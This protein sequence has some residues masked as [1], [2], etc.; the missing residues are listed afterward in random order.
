[1]EVVVEEEVQLQLQ[2]E[3]VVTEILVVEVVEVERV[4]LQQV[5]E[6]QEDVEVMV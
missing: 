3:M 1:V 6:E 2:V 5:L 4:L